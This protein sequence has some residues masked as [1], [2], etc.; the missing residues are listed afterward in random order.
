MGVGLFLHL[1]L[2]P[3]AHTFLIQSYAINAF[4]A[5]VALMLLV[6]GIDK[7]KSNLAV[8]YLLTVALKFSV[9]FIFFYP[10]FYED[11]VLIR[12]EFFV[13]F[14]PYALGLFLEIVLLARRYN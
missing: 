6:W 7:K 2:N 5:C 10:K 11:G 4:L 9:Y 12:Q 8:L 13:F 3:L 1:Q 14:V